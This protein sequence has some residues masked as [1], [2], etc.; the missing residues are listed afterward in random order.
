MR[1]EINKFKKQNGNQSFT[2]KEMIMYLITKIDG[3]DEKLTVGTGK[4]A[5]NRSRI[6]GLITMFKVGIPLLFA[7]LTFLL[8]KVMGG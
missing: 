1:K 4:I 3:I 2:N 8:V 6:T 7:V 5:E